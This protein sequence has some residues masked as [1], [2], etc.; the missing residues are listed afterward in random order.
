MGIRFEGPTIEH[1]IGAEIISDGIGPGAI[2]VPRAVLPMALL[3]DRQ[4]VGSYP[5]IATVASADLPRLGRLPPG[6][7]VRFTPVSID[8][9]RCRVTIRRHASRT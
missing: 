9:A 2:Q 5:K 8:E 3:A 1:A 6:Q 4:T 7:T